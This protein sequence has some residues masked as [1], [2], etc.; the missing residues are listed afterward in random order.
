VRD[1]RPAAD[2]A[3]ILVFAVV[4]MLSHHRLG[5]AGFARDALPLLAGWFA[6]AAA[7]RLYRRRAGRRL[8]A[9]WAVGIPAGLVVRRLA[10][11]HGLEPAFVATTLVFTLALVL[12][13]R[14]ALRIGRSRRRGLALRRPRPARR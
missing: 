2:A 7:F 12:A 5:A 4:G 8:A 6:A 9:T 1:L 3:A 10:L 13:G 11:G 14:L